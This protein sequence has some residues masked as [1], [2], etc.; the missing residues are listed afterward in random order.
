LLEVKVR[1][2]PRADLSGADRMVERCCA[3]EGLTMTVRRS[4]RM[5]EDNVHWHFRKEGE[6]GT[7]EITLLRAER[8]ISLYIHD[9]R[10]GSW[11]PS[12]IRSL[13]P[14][15]ERGLKSE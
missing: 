5:S 11:I 15:I 13:K 6:R 10:R 8:G 1:V 14:A 7:L 3:N 2:P 12:T 4:L 9:N